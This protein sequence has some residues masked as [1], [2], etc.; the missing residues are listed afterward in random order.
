MEF[1]ENQ[2]FSLNVNG[3]PQLVHHL[4]SDNPIISPIT[5]EWQKEKCDLLG[6]QFQ[7]QTEQHS[8]LAG[9]VL[10][11]F[12]PWRSASITGD[13]NCLFRCLS[14]VIS[15]SEEDHAK[16]RG[17]ICRYMLGEGKEEI[18]W[19]FSQVLSTTPAEYLGQSAMYVAGTWGSDVEL[20][21]ASA[22][23][24]TDIYVANRIYRTPDSLI[25]EVRWSRICASND[26]SEDC[27]IYITNY[28]D[29]Y[30]PVT[31]M[32]NS[33]TPTFYK[34]DKSDQIINID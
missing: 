8:S 10:G 17:E 19:Y 34:D 4:K 18:S 28:H 30:E 26:N 3:F 12:E 2:L 24:K 23:L 1:I 22:L 11:N 13:G 7:K 15:G 32:M 5:I 16:L 14:K 33:L 9:Q 21:A 29:H 31:T 6:I 27:A 20:M 25:P